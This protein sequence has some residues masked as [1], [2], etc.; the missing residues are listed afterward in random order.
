MPEQSKLDASV[1]SYGISLVVTTI[2]GA[3]FFAAKA[4]NPEFAEGMEATFGHSW[5]SQGVLSLAVF[6]L[7]GLILGKAKTSGKGLAVAV[8]LGVVLSGLILA[9]AAFA[10]ALIGESGAPG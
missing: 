7:L 3:L 2:L 10:G 6:V 4:A 8:A 9:V 1:S 5:L